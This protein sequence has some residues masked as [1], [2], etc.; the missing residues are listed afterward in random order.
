[1]KAYP[2]TYRVSADG[3]T[4]GTVAVAAADLPEIATAPPPEF[5]GPGGLWSPESLLVAS[6]ANCFFLTFR[7]IARASRFEWTHLHC[8][9]D[10]VLDRVAGVT[11]FCR[12]T[13]HAVLTVAPGASHEKARELLE[14]AEKHCLITNSLRGERHLEIELTE[15]K[16]Q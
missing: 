6:V 3:E 16:S 12:F 11:Y 15:A 7:A 14:R 8:H 4:A 1:M 13:T 9:V 2:H 10:G 5:D